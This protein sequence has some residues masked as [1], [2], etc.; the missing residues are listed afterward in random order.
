MTCWTN[1][2]V[3]GIASLW[4]KSCRGSLAFALA[5]N[6]ALVATTNELR[7]FAVADGAT[8]W[9]F[10]LPAAPV[11]W[12]LAVNRDGRV[13][14][15]LEDGRLLTVGPALGPLTIIRETDG[16][17]LSWSGAGRLQVTAS[18]TPLAWTDVTSAASPYA[19][20]SA[21]GERYYRLAEEEAEGVTVGP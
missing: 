13:L 17:V 12:G 1:G 11:P 16:V 4:A 8:R 5:A 7:A 2:T 14:V 3:P 9:S 21:G 6:A 19:V 15:A 20:V 10:R 18:L